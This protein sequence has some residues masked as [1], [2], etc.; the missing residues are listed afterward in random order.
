MKRIIGWTLV[1]LFGLMLGAGPVAAQ[2]P[3]RGGTVN[4]VAYGD[5]ARLDLHKESVL[6]VA[7]ATGGVFSGLLQWDPARTDK[8]VPDLATGYEVSNNG[9]PYTYRPYVCAGQKQYKT[10]C[11]TPLEPSAELIEG[12]VLGLLADTFSDP[13]KVLA[14]CQA[15]GDQLRAEQ[16]EQEG[17][18][19]ALK[20]HLAKAE[21]E[22]DR[23]IELYGKGAIKEAVLNKRLSA[24]DAD[25]A[26]S[27]E[28]LLRLEEAAQQKAVVQEIEQSA[29]AIAEQ[30]KPTIDEMTLEEKKELVRTL[31]ER[32]WVDSENEV[33]VECVVPG[34]IPDRNTATTRSRSP[35]LAG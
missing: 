7:I 1:V 8:I 9:K 14:A 4:F 29:Y 32:V 10:K 21:A 11:R 35:A 19:A 27:E 15:Y 18:V 28:D 13:V 31:A 3:K 30:I 23:Y 2:T 34:L 5:P 12:N 20:R 24:L 22:R 16:E 33:T 26:K 6:S 17:H 25:A